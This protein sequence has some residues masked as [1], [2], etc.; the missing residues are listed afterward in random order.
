[1]T[2]WLLL[3]SRDILRQ[4]YLV[5]LV[6]TCLCFLC[7]QGV[8]VIEGDITLRFLDGLTTLNGLGSLVS[9]NGELLLHDLPRLASTR[10]LTSFTSVGE[11][12]QLHCLQRVLALQS[13]V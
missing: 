9:T 5:Q 7:L 3:S 8:Q 4:G 6:Q 12:R 13:S 1:M 10:G 2:S 11:H